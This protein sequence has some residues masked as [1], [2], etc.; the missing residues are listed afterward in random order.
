[1]YSEKQSMNFNHD[2]L[3]N[4]IKVK[5]YNIYLIIVYKCNIKYTCNSQSTFTFTSVNIF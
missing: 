1:M 3:Y 4:M 5:K 2:L